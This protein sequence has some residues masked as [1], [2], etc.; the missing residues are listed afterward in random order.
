MSGAVE[1]ILMSANLL[2]FLVYASLFNGIVRT[3]EF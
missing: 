2:H 3:I 1:G